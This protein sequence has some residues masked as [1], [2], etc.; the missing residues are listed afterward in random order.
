[1][2]KGITNR[3]K[4]I[5]DKI[6]IIEKNLKKIGNKVDLLEESNKTLASLGQKLE[7]TAQKLDSNVTNNDQRLKEL[8][9]ARILT[10]EDLEYEVKHMVI[11]MIS[12]SVSSV[13][14][15]II[16]LFIFCCLQRKLKKQIKNMDVKREMRAMEEDFHK[17]NSNIRQEK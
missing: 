13:I 8:E 9:A 3:V 16:V 14:G 11:V 2:I 10:K 17:K 12:V 1:M 5:E 7:K 6:D 15:F 4:N